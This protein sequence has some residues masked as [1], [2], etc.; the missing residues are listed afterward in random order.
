MGV[1]VVTSM[2]RYLVGWSE[3]G[4]VVDMIFGRVRLRLWSFPLGRPRAGL[5]TMVIG[6]EI[7]IGRGVFQASEGTVQRCCEAVG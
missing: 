1:G 3:L 4:V 5:V 7:R 6:V 2:F